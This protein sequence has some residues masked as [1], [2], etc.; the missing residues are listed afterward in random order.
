MWKILMDCSEFKV[1]LW[2]KNKNGVLYH[3]MG[4][5][6]PSKIPDGTKCV[7][8]CS[9]WV[10]VGTCSSHS[11]FTVLQFVCGQCVSWW[12]LSVPCCPISLIWSKSVILQHGLTIGIIF[13]DGF[14]WYVEMYVILSLYF[15]NAQWTQMTKQPTKQK[16]AACN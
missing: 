5:K 13:L 12:F 10:L 14:W 16:L 3:T 8:Y 15:K 1:G 9:V 11:C 4:K 2:P 7:V 6:N